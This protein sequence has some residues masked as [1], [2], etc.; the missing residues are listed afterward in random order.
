MTKDEALDR[1][2]C[3]RCASFAPEIN[4]Q[5]CGYVRRGDSVECRLTLAQ[6]RERVQMAKDAKKYNHKDGRITG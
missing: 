5:Y 3:L 4:Q 6:V 2:I 1:G